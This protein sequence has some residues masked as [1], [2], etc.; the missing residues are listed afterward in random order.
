MFLNRLKEEE[1]VAFLELAHHI[2]RSD[3]DFSEAEANV[4]A[5]YCLEMQ[6]DDINYKE[7]NFNLELILRKIADKENQKIVVLEIMALIYSDGLHNEEQK[8]LEV[9]MIEYNISEALYIVYS[10]WSKS[11]L[12]VS[13]QGQALIKL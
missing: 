5:T 6:I 7:D 11:I 12:A 1:K 8:I 3:G 13:N 4:I 2:A 10:E 9:I